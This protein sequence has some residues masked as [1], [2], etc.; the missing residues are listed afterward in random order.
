MSFS[1]NFKQKLIIFSFVVLISYVLDITRNTCDDLTFSIKCNNLVHHVVSNYLWFGSIIFGFH[2][3]HIVYM[4]GGF[5]GWKL[6]DGCF[7]TKKYNETCN[8]NESNK[9][10]DLLYFIS[11]NEE[12]FSQMNMFKIVLIYN[13]S[14]VISKYLL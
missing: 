12:L 6:F 10:H 3:L 13:I 1:Y 11:N 4:M 2:E 7:L 8:Y 9:H 5:I 14:C